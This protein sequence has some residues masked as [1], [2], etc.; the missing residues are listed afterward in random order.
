MAFWTDKNTVPLQ[1]YRY[2]VITNL[3]IYPRIISTGQTV[4]PKGKLRNYKIPTHLISSVDLPGFELQYE[5]N[6]A[7]LSLETDIQG[8]SADLGELSLKLIMT[9]QLMRDIPKMVQGYWE[10][11]IKSKVPAAFVPRTGLTHISNILI[12][13]Y[14]SSGQVVRKLGY[15][16]VQPIGYKLGDIKYGDSDVIEGE[17][18]FYYESTIAASGKDDDTD[19][20]TAPQEVNPA[21]GTP[22]EPEPLPKAEPVPEGEPTAGGFGN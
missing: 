13:F 3:W 12:Y 10:T 15:Y 17:V 16:K 11:P 4:V 21:T 5:N 2:Q 22:P 8:T 6:A 1:K 19:D 9:P 18:K 20:S 7:K 14:D